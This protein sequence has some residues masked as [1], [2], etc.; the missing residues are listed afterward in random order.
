MAKR[1]KPAGTPVV[2]DEAYR[3]RALFIL[4]MVLMAADVDDIAATYSVDDADETLECHPRN[5]PPLCG[6]AFC[7][8]EVNDLYVRLPQLLGLPTSD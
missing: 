8:R 1:K 6:A 7:D 4:R 5:K 3:Q 2:I